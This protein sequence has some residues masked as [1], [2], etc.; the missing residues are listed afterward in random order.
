[1]QV[2]TPEYYHHFQC[3]ASACPDSCCK[4][5]EVDVDEKSAAYYRAL[6]GALGDSLRRVLKDTE[7]GTVM[8]I[9]NGRCPMW[10][11]DGLCR[12]QAAL[13]H[14]ALCM[15]AAPSRACGMTTETLRNWAWSYP[16]RKR[17]G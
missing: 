3:I 7:D 2:W 6:P 14:E 13:G 5:W 12:I 9:L 16:V 1:M 15:S 8:T 4:E 10:R 11:E 17:H